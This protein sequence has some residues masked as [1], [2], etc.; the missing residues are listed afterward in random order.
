LR[1]P[2]SAIAGSLQQNGYTDSVQESC[3]LG[4]LTDYAAWQNTLIDFTFNPF[5]EFDS[6]K[7]VE[8]FPFTYSVMTLCAD[9]VRPR[10]ILANHALNYTIPSN[11][12]GI[13]NE[14]PTLYAQNSS[15]L[16]STS[17]PPCLVSLVGAARSP[18]Q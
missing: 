13:Y 9:S 10:C 18:K 17:R 15:A 7:S 8:N 4:A 3:L 11:L 1:R 12:Q 5:H 2:I 14:M 16:S 6:G